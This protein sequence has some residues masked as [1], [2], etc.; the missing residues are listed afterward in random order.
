MNI[1]KAQ[2]RDSKRKKKPATRIYRESKYED[3]IAKDKNIKTAR[4]IKR[5]LEDTI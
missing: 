1:S 4:K 5:E 2:N 3:F